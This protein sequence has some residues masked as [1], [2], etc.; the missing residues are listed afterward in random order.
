M[1]PKQL[2]HIGERFYR[3]DDSGAI[4]GSGLGV[5]L[6]REIVTIHAGEVEFSSHSGEGMTVTVWLPIVKN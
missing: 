3:A 5:S 6:V 1:T 2:T 4:P